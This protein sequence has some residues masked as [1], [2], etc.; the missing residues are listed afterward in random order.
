THYP[1]A[2]HA[3]EAGKHVMVEKPL[4]LA[5]DECEK[6]VAAAER[7]N[8]VLLV[9]HN[10]Q[11]KPAAETLMGLIADGTLGDI[12]HIECRRLDLGKLRSHENV[13][14]SFAPHDIAFILA[15]AG[16]DPLEVKAHG[17]AIL[18]PGVH[19]TVHCDLRFAR[20]SA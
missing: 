15:L 2:M 20:L 13:F 3:L 17:S 1:P 7:L 8:K 9:G 5:V 14:W 12:V 11:Y 18:Q 10:Q 6:L 16:E 4:T 19:D